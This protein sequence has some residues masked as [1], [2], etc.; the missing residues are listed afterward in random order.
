MR[1][2]I[3]V[4]ASL[5]VL[6]GAARSSAQ[7]AGAP[8]SPPPLEL[9]DDDGTD[10]PDDVRP[11]TARGPTAATSG[12]AFDRVVHLRSGRTIRCSVIETLP[13]V[14]LTVV[15]PSGRTRVIPWSDVA[16]VVPYV[17]PRP[18]RA[19][20]GASSP[21]AP[22]PATSP[23]SARVTPPTRRTAT[24][25]STT[26]A[27]ARSS[28]TAHPTGRSRTTTRPGGTPPRRARPEAE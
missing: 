12:L 10:G 20:P 5:A 14:R 28:A 13:D 18:R 16:G 2:P 11:R 1:G 24:A 6:A 19:P 27:G 3:V 25:T 15:L 8:M 9:P 4:V 26:R 17:A 21:A 23:S 22:P 7:D